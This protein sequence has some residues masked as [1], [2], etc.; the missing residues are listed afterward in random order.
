MPL[1]LLLLL[2]RTSSTWRRRAIIVD[3]QREQR[4]QEMPKSRHVLRLL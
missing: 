3:R 1:R 4:A 2:D